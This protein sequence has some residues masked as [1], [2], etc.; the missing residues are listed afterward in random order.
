LAEIRAFGV[1]DLELSTVPA[2]HVRTLARYAATTWAPVIARMPRYS[3]HGH[4]GGVR[5]RVR[6]H[7]PGRCA[8]LLDLMIGDLLTRVENE[9]DQARLRTLRDLDAAALRLRDACRVVGWRSSADLT[10]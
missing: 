1:G 10:T 6:S 5:A 3:S 4:T 8:G 2:G 7:C 9:G